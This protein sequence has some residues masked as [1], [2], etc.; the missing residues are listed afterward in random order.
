[1]A[2]NEATRCTPDRRNVARYRKL[3]GVQDKLSLALRE[4]FAAQRQA[5]G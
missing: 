5:A 2:L 1:V 3:Q 4:V